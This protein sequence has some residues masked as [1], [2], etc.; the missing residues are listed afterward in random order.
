MP[1]DVL[2][3]E[4][5]ELSHGP[6][7]VNSSGNLVVTVWGTGSCGITVKQEDAC[8]IA[9]AP[10]MAAELDR[11]RESN[12]ELVK[13]LK[14]IYHR[15]FDIKFGPRK[16]WHPDFLRAYDLTKAAIAKAEA[17]R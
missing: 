14:E 7:L 11:L 4:D 5:A 16:F 13:A 9:A 3:P 17:R 6:I 12:K 8:L 10:E 2:E 15:L 1:K